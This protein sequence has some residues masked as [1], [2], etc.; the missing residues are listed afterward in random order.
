MLAS[1]RGIDDSSARLQLKSGGR[2]FIAG[3]S[4]DVQESWLAVLCKTYKNSGSIAELR[5]NGA[6]SKPIARRRAPIAGYPQAIV[7]VGVTAI[8]G[9]AQEQHWRLDEHARSPHLMGAPEIADDL[10]IIEGRQGLGIGLA[11]P[12]GH[13]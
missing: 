4:R 1:R 3:Q 7:V 10:P 12:A 13:A 5:V 6:N 2:W 9:S 8:R 11:V